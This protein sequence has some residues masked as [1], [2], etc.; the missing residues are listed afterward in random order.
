MST[1]E[2]RVDRLEDTVLRQHRSSMTRLLILE[3]GQKGVMD[4]L[5]GAEVAPGVRDFKQGMFHKFTNN[6]DTRRMKVTRIG[7]DIALSLLAAKEIFSQ[8]WM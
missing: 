3:E 6:H 5:F 4:T 2:D 7:R 1:L 8:V